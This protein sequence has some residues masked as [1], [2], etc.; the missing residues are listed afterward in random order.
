MILLIISNILMGI[1]LCLS[2]WGKKVIDLY[3]TK[4]KQRESHRVKEIHNIIDD[5]LKTILE[6]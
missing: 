5:Y 6:E 3:K 4:K 2:L 1:A